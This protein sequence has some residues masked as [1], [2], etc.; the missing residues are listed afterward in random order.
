M[1]RPHRF[2][3][4]SGLGCLVQRY[5]QCRTSVMGQ[6][7][8]DLAKL[9]Q[10]ML[11]RVEL[12]IQSYLRLKGLTHSQDCSSERGAAHTLPASLLPARSVARSLYGGGWVTCGSQEASTDCSC[13]RTREMS[14]PVTLS[15]SDRTPILRT[16]TVGC[17]HARRCFTVTPRRPA[18]CQ[19]CWWETSVPDSFSPWGR[20]APVVSTLDGKM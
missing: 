7:C 5:N 17:D 1:N 11:L 19:D 4:Q 10:I 18:V 2:S 15:W 16:D 13:C 8:L 20:T 14:Q 3:A 9:P 12:R 6:I